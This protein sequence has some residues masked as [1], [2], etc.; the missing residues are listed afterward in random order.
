MLV[1]T[2][3]QQLSFGGFVGRILLK[4]AGQGLEDECKSII[5]KQPDIQHGDVVT[6]RAH[7]LNSKHIVH[8]VL[9]GYSG[10]Q[11]ETVN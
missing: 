8:V 1:N 6:T 3:D 4:A 10:V 9:P 7:Q 5:A 2:T 11:S